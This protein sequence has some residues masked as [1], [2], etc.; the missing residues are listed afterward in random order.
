[1]SFTRLANTVEHHQ[2]QDEVLNPEYPQ[3]GIL[4]GGQAKF[5]EL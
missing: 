5:R 3:A 2:S 4:H 1:M